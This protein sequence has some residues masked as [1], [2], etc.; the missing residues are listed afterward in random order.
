M[1]FTFTKVPS[2]ILIIL[3]WTL[4]NPDLQNLGRCVAVASKTMGGNVYTCLQGSLG[5]EMEN[6]TLQTD[7]N[8]EITQAG[9]HN[10]TEQRHSSS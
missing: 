10:S 5:M 7:V 9:A 8:T 4:N 1:D 2:E 3:A 6:M